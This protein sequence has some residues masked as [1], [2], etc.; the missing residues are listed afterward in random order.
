MN[1]F[2]VLCLVGAAAA[3]DVC[4]PSPNWVRVE[5]WDNEH[6]AF[7]EAK[8]ILDVAAKSFRQ[9]TLG[10]IHHGRSPRPVEI[11]QD[12]L[13]L[14][15]KN[16]TYITVGDPKDKRTWRCRVIKDAVQIKDPC[17]THNGTKIR[18]ETIG[19][20]AVDVFYGED[21]H[22]G[23]TQ[24]AQI[25]ITK[26]GIPVSTTTWNSYSHLERLF[27]DFN[28]TLPHEA[29]KPLSICH[30]KTPEDPTPEDIAMIERH[31]VRM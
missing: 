25:L 26:G 20:T 11:G 29:F 31:A 30:G 24:Y 12:L 8:E 22:H 2:L 28:R 6:D 4:I 17:I 18:T 27:S 9:D 10:V 21:K 13:I 5:E 23:V 16:L 1:F 7:A 15:A 3:V 19:T 14:A